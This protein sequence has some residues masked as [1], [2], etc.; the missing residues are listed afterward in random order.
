MSR[1]MNAKSSG[2]KSKTVASRLARKQREVV[3][4]CGGG[5]GDGGDRWCRRWCG[6]GGHRGGGGG[7]GDAVVSSSAGSVLFQRPQYWLKKEKE[8]RSG[9]RK[10]IL[11]KA[12]AR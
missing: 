4:P 10:C 9:R 11:G 7:G 5:G 6:C 2:H 8:S 1:T 3:L 12:D